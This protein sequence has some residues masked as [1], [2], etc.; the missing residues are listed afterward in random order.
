MKLYVTYR[1]VWVWDMMMMMIVMGLNKRRIHAYIDNIIYCCK[2][3]ELY[4]APC[5]KF[6][7]LYDH[8]NE[9]C[10]Y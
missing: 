8:M 4:D 10:L 6:S 5:Y 3:E 2:E 7:E 1:G 9:L